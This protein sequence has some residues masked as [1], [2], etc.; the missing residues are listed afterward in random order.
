MVVLVSSGLVIIAA[1]LIL[2]LASAMID[3]SQNNVVAHVPYVISD[4]ACAREILL[5][6]FPDSHKSTC[7][8][9]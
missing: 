3:K 6:R 5:S 7:G 8:K 2:R 9:S 4:K 1:A